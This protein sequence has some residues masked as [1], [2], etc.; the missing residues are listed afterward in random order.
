[1]KIQV[2][3]DD[4]R[5]IRRSKK[6]GPLDFIIYFEHDGATYPDALWYD[7]G[8]VILTW[9]LGA[10]SGLANGG[11]SAVFN[12]VEGPYALVMNLHGAESMLVVILQGRNDHWLTTLGEVIQSLIRVS[13]E[14][15]AK[16]NQLNIGGSE[17]TALE[18][19]LAQLK[20]A[21]H[22]KEMT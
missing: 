22:P 19:S 1:M 10:A 12:F 9:W 15:I 8:V 13:E 20:K 4:T 5:L 16:L 2:K 6:D 7:F 3:F 21:W 11:S 18:H 14:V 17:A